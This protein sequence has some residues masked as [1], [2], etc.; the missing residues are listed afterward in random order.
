[1]PGFKRNKK[2]TTPPPIF[3]GADDELV[4]DLLEQ[5]E[6]R[7]PVLQT[8]TAAVVQTMHLH[9]KADIL[10]SSRKQDAKS[11]FQ[12]RQVRLMSITLGSCSD[13]DLNNRGAK[14]QTWHKC[15]PLMTHKLM[16]PS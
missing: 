2:P 8:Q 10:E 1:M 16:Q 4:D 7:D 12:A 13:H 14:Q 3:G 6:S 9:E 5:L 11:R 15:I